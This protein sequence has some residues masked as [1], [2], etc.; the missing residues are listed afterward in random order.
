[1]KED[2]IMSEN[3]HLVFSRHKSSRTL[4]ITDQNS[5]LIKIKVLKAMK[6][7]VARKT[8]PASKKIVELQKNTILP[9]F[10][11]KFNCLA[12]FTML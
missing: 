4:T 9:Q 8:I 6:N 1:M 3:H 10:N 12:S 5:N 11:N 7:M 2:V